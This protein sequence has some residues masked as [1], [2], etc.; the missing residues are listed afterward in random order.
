[1]KYAKVIINIL[2]NSTYLGFHKNVTISI[3]RINIGAISVSLSLR[4]KIKDISFGE[5]FHIT[6]TFGD[7]IILVADELRIPY[8]PQSTQQSGMVETGFG[9]T[10][11]TMSSRYVND[12]IQKIVRS[13]YY[14]DKRCQRSVRV[15]IKEKED[16]PLEIVYNGNKISIALEQMITFANFIKNN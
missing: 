1:M 2:N 15:T 5:N 11:Y 16:L 14:W 6:R 12:F 8:I 4:E 3:P 9:T 7:S 10:T 13:L